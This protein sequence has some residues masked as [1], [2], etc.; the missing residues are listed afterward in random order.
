MEIYV[1]VLPIRSVK[2]ILYWETVLSSNQFHL[3]ITLQLG[4]RVVVALAGRDCLAVVTGV[5]F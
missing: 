2:L 3:K 5:I 4:A 1:L